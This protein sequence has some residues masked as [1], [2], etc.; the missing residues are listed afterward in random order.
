MEELTTKRLFLHMLLNGHFRQRSTVGTAVA[1]NPPFFNPFLLN[2]GLAASR[3]DKHSFFIQH[4]SF[5]VHGFLFLMASEDGTL[6]ERI[7]RLVKKNA[8]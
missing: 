1:P 7:A 3:T 5:F 6:S 4:T 8:I 2:I